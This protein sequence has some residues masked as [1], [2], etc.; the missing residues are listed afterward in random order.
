[1]ELLYGEE[2]VKNFELENKKLIET[3][4]SNNN[5]NTT[6][7]ASGNGV[8]PMNVD[9][10]P[11]SAEGEKKKKNKKAKKDKEGENKE[12]SGV[13]SDSKG[14]SKPAKGTEKKDSKPVN[15]STS[16]TGQNIPQIGN[17]NIFAVSGG[18]ARPSINAMKCDS[19][20]DENNVI[21]QENDNVNIDNM[22]YGEAEDGF[23][24]EDV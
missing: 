14:K 12:K 1:M 10:N 23:E 18:G 20:D 8:V 3:H 7:N 21:I 15:P 4:T 9:K 5:N 24:D 17:R 11:A 6:N 16:L 22:D 2:E 13:P 19:S